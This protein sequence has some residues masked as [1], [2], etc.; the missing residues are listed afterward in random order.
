M[1][2]IIVMHFANL[3]V[4]NKV[5]WIFVY[6]IT[7]L[8]TGSISMRKTIRR[9]TCNCRSNSETQMWSVVCYSPNSELICVCMH[10][11]VCLCVY[12]YGCVSLCV[13]MGMCACIN[14][15]RRSCQ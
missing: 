3:T 12:I 2:R 14:M 8:E 5:K 1:R 11:D 4:I 13:C 9:S 15:Q 10:L 6:R 7:K